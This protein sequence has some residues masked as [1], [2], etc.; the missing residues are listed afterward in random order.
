MICLLSVFTPKTMALQFHFETIYYYLP[1]LL[2]ALNLIWINEH[3]D[4]IPRTFSCIFNDDTFSMETGC[5]F[6]LPILYSMASWRQ[7]HYYTL[8]PGTSSPVN[9]LCWP[10]FSTTILFDV[11]GLGEFLLKSKCFNSKTKWPKM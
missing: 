5:V 11:F 8:V 9:Y 4:F 7:I 6:D 10:T 3:F 2:T 1:N